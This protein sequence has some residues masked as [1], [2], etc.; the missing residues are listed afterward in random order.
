MIFLAPIQDMSQVLGEDISYLHMSIYSINF[1]RLPTGSSFATYGHTRLVYYN[2]SVV[3]CRLIIP[4]KDCITLDELMR[5]A[6]SY[7]KD[8]FC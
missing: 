7:K 2:H 3:G 1:S 5:F 4:P 8:I 6:I